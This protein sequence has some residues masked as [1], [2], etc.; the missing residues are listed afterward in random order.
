MSTRKVIPAKPCSRCP[1]SIDT[2]PGEFTAEK[3][4]EMRSCTGD[5][6]T[7]GIAAMHH[8]FACHRSRPGQEYICPGV[9]MIVGEH[10]L[11]ARIGVAE[12]RIPPMY[13]Q[14]EPPPDWPPLFDSYDQMARCQGRTPDSED[15]MITET[16]RRYLYELASMTFARIHQAVH[17]AESITIVPVD[18]NPGY[19]TYHQD[20]L[21]E[22][23]RSYQD[24]LKILTGV[25]GDGLVWALY[26]QHHDTGELAR[27]TGWDATSVT[28]RLRREEARQITALVT[29]LKQLTPA[30]SR[31]LI[32]DLYNQAAFIM[33]DLHADELARLDDDDEE[34]RHELASHLGSLPTLPVITPGDTE[35]TSFPD[36]DSAE[37]LMDGDLRTW[38]VDLV[39]LFGPR[40]L[41]RLRAALTTLSGDEQAED[42]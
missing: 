27:I 42:R 17:S 33:A 29:A 25:V 1:A 37:L 23:M 4:A 18:D 11:G 10:H 36:P 8:Y 14:G 13:V 9:L 3:F 22:A 24:S 19:L 12:G 40:M 6:A 26:L 32:D 21:R 31:A 20:A 15:N 35:E 16:D 7:H 5:A 38:L 41:I 30:Q 34:R 2:P 39:D 28:T